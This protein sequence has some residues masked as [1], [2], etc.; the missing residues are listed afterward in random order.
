MKNGVIDLKTREFRPARIDEMIQHTTGRNY[1]P[2][3]PEVKKQVL[4][5]LCNIYASTD[6]LMTKLISVSSSLRGKNV[7]QTF[8]M[9]TGSGGNGKGTVRDLI[10]ACFGDLCGTLDKLAIQS[11]QKDVGQARSDLAALAYCRIVFI[12]ET[13]SMLPLICPTMKQ[14]SGGDPIICRAL[15][16]NTFTF[17]PGFQVFVICNKPP[18]LDESAM[19]LSEKRALA[20]RLLFLVNPFVFDNGDLPFCKKSS[21]V[22]EFFATPE[23]LDAFL[24]ILLTVY[25]QFTIHFWDQD[26][27]KIK[28]MDK[29]KFPSLHTLQYPQYWDE[30]MQQYKDAGDNV[31]NF[32]SKYESKCPP[33]WRQTVKN[34]KV[35]IR[36]KK[37]FVTASGDSYTD[38]FT[39]EGFRENFKEFHDHFKTSLPKSVKSADVA[40]FRQGIMDRGFGITKHDCDGHEFGSGIEQ[41]FGIYENTEA[42]DY[43]V[44]SPFTNDQGPDKGPNSI[45][46]LIL[47]YSPLS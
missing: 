14:I 27:N 6:Q 38:A 11:R 26:V 20:R 7:F 3:K 34:F 5:E 2:A 43:Y 30:R 17:V 10:A 19:E 24:E 37:Q 36:T 8:N 18:P 31:Q 16:G 47:T 40:T 25:F 21:D 45:Y 12:N 1:A 46:E 35:D 41:I 42:D 32:L 33:G 15:Y 29:V 4:D 39:Q 23:A 22:S 13:D 44:E 9:E 28:D